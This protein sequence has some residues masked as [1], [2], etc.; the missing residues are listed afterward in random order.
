MKP[1]IIAFSAIVA[2]VGIVGMKKPDYVRNMV[3]SFSP[4]GENGSALPLG[5]PQLQPS[6][7]AAE[8]KPPESKT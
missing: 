5:Q 2:A 4:V 8:E 1:S 3:Q 7:R 6:L